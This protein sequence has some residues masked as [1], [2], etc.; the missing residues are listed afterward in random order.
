MLVALIDDGINTAACPSLPVRH[1]LSVGPDGRI[2]NRGANDRI[3]TGHGTTC[4]KI[5][6]KYAPKAEFCSLRIF[7]KEQLRASCRQLVAAMEW[8]LA[9]R[10]PIVHMSLGTSQANDFK[11]IR[12]ITARMIQQGQIIVAARSNSATFSLPADLSGVLAVVADKELA[13]D[14]YSIGPVGNNLIRASSRHRL[15]SP[16]GGFLTPVTNSYAAPTLSAAVHKILEQ[17]GLPRPVTQIFSELARGKSKMTFPRP[18][19]IEDA[20]ILNLAGVSLLQRH[21][22]FHC[23]EVVLDPASLELSPGQSLVYLPPK[24]T[25]F[26]PFIEGILPKAGALVYGGSLLEREKGVLSSGLVWSEDCCMYP[27]GPAGQS[28]DLPPIVIVR[29]QGLKVLDVMCRLC[30][31]FAQD[32]YHCRGLSDLPYSYLYGLEFVPNGVSPESALAHVCEVYQP[33]VVI[34]SIHLPGREDAALQ[35]VHLIYLEDGERHVDISSSENKSY[36]Q[37][38]YDSDDILRLYKEILQHFCE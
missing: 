15:V 25:G 32:G 37:S 19:F 21:L 5:I 26:S 6:A 11:C 2:G 30:A 22:F 1:D 33:E 20:L 24:G 31:L 9:A 36:L 23:R 7:H 27:Q 28:R 29:G 3:L 12:S 17:S 13:D 14:E 38:A 18:D 16:W 35:D 8:C 4:A 10:V 34:S